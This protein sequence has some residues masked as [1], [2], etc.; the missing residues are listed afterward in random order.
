MR[1]QR[2]NHP[3]AKYPAI[4]FFLSI[5]EFCAVPAFAQQ[6]ITLEGEVTSEAASVIGT[7]VLLAL[8]TSDGGLVAQQICGSDGRFEFNGLDN[9]LYRLRVTA[10]GFQ[11]L[12]KEVDLNGPRHNVHIDIVLLPLTKTKTMTADLPALT[13]EAAPRKARKEYERGSRALRE[14]KL[15]QAQLHLEK[16]VEEYPCYARA[17]TD[18]ALAFV[19]QK[20]VPSAEAALRKSISCDADYLEAYSRLGIL[21]DN[22]NRYSES[23]KILE[24]GLRRFPNSW[25]L[26]YQLAAACAGL[27]QFD[28]AEEQYL[29]VRSL[30]PAPPA[31]LHVRLADLFQRMKNYEKA[32]VEM[33]VYLKEDPNGRFADRT[34]TVIRKMES[35]GMIHPVQTQPSPPPP[36]DH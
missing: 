19:W 2:P 5:S 24:E 12:E 28:K 11:T 13:D 16:A 36:Q 26:H 29:K 21:L 9:A 20:N 3:I 31:E 17:Q 6:K 22:T 30:N 25:D 23:E 10:P 8:E 7:P 32:Y 27:E 34:R 35:S 18:L 33:Q 14:K 1:H 15:D 4:I